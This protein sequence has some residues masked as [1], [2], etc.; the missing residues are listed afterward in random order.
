MRSAV[1]GAPSAR[2]VSELP[3]KDGQPDPDPA[4]PRTCFSGPASR[5]EPAAWSGQSAADPPGAEPGQGQGEAEVEPGLGPL[6]GPEI[7]GGMVGHLLLVAQGAEGGEA[8]VEFVGR[9]PGC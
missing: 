1:N 5:S 3:R 4:A 6:E 7:A 8:G 9:P 2:S